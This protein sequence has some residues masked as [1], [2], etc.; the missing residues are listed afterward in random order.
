MVNR[1]NVLCHELVRDQRLFPV[2]ICLGNKMAHKSAKRSAEAPLE[3][4]RSPIADPMA[5]AKLSRRLVR[6]ALIC[7]LHTVAE[8]K[9][10]RRGVKEV[11]KNLRKK[12][13]GIVLIAADI[14]PIDLISHI[15]VMCETRDI[16]YIYVPSKD[17]L[18]Q[19][20]IS[21]RSTTI[22]MLARPSKSSELYDEY[23]KYA[24]LVKRA[25]PYL[26]E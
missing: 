19:G 3:D 15:P 13:R 10:A 9:M 6:L 22:L 8:N 26:N 20:A 24:E 21:K 7:K 4:Y 12:K 2:P 17:F 14:T 23:K 5:E 16:P 1:V 11:V 25:N 18:G